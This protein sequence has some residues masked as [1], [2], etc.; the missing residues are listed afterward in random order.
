[1]HERQF[2][3]VWRPNSRLSGMQ[4]NQTGAHATNELSRVQMPCLCVRVCVRILHYFCVRFRAYVSGTLLRLQLCNAKLNGPTAFDGGVR[5]VDGFFRSSHTPIGVHFKCTP[6]RS[7]HTL[8]SRTHTFTDPKHTQPKKCAPYH[9][10]VRTNGQEMS[11][12]IVR[13]N[14]DNLIGQL[15]A[16][17]CDWLWV[18]GRSCTYLMTRLECAI[19]V[20]AFEVPGNTVCPSAAPCG[21][22]IDRWNN[23][24]KMKCQTVNYNI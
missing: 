21:P 24:K 19:L 13:M 7:M 8:Y 6:F 15:L 5:R 11:L 20:G 3:A 14:F 16:F 1:M 4:R 10:H 23:V 18:D 9:E 22:F 12:Y 2:G 17:I